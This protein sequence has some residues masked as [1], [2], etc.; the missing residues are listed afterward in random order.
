[1]PPY[2]VPRYGETTKRLSINNAEKDGD[3]ILYILQ[4]ASCTIEMLSFKPY[5]T[6]RRQKMYV[7][8]T[9]QISLVPFIH[10]FVHDFNAKV[11]N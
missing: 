1:M 7:I 5:E 6:I 11:V 2:A 10:S 9:L 3:M 8:Y 4:C